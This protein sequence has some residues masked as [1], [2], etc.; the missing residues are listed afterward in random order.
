MVSLDRI[1]M[2]DLTMQVPQKMPSAEFCYGYISKTSIGKHL[3][4]V[5]KVVLSLLTVVI[6][7]GQA[8]ASPTNDCSS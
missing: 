1:F 4:I 3:F 7:Y 8:C 5:H 2:A 6:F